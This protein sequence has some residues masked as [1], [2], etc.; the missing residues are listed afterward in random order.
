MAACCV[1]SNETGSITLIIIIII[2]PFCILL[3]FTLKPSPSVSVAGPDS[4]LPPA[5]DAALDSP[6]KPGRRALAA[7][8]RRYCRRSLDR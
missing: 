6:Q 1:G 8:G 5:V 3:T 7:G 4:I 2:H